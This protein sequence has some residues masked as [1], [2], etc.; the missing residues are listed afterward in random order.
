MSVRG[1]NQGVIGCKAA[2]NRLRET[3]VD[4]NTRESDIR[5]ESSYYPG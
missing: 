4:F 5:R 2:K 1:C 3:N